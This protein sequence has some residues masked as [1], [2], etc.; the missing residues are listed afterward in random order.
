MPSHSLPSITD[1]YGLGPFI[2]L[3]EEYVGGYR[4][5]TPDEQENIELKREHSLKVLEEAS[6]I[7]EQ[8]GLNHAD[9]RLALLGALFHD[10]G[11]FPQYL[12]YGTFRDDASENHA[13]LGLRTVRARN[14]FSALDQ[15]ERNAVHQAILLHNRRALPGLVRGRAK[16]IC[17]VVRDADKL[18]ILRVLLSHLEP[19]GRRNSVVTLGLARDPQAY[20]PSLVESIRRGRMARYEEMVWENDFVILLLSW[21]YD[22]NFQATCGMVLARGYLERLMALLPAGPPFSDLHDGLSRQLTSR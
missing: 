10:A 11:R 13:L 16:V 21:I 18:D 1:E 4:A 2:Q 9:R 5:P 6:R 14:V 19:N 7:V 12:T 15:D 20:T 17:Q 22:L 3:F 8:S